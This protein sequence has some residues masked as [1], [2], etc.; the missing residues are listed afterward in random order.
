MKSLHILW[1]WGTMFTVVV[2]IRKLTIILELSW[3]TQIEIH[4]K[5]QMMST[6]WGEIKFQYWSVSKLTELIFFSCDKSESIWI[7]KSIKIIIWK[8]CRRNILGRSKEASTLDKVAQR[9]WLQDELKLDSL[10][11]KKE[12][13][14]SEIIFR[15]ENKKN[16]T[17][18]VEVFGYFF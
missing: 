6:Y 8:S 18:R 1:F 13:N 11:I 5:K 10:A 16:N 15:K 2:I 14:F 7:T 17:P 3:N 9:P 12:D 4:Y